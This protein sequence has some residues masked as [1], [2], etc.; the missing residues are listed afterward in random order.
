MARRSVN[1]MGDQ[2]TV[3]HATRPVNSRRL[4]RSDSSGDLI[5]IVLGRA[6]L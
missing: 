1:P 6:A 5:G 3:T 4:L 2:F